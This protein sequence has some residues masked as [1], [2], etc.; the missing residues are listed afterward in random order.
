MEVEG[1]TGGKD[2]KLYPGAGRAWDSSPVPRR[3]LR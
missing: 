1:L 3:E 2:F